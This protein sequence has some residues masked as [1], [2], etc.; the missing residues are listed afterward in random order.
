MFFFVR[1]F[2]QA[3]KFCPVAMYEYTL[4]KAVTENSKKRLQFSEKINIESQRSHDVSS[5]S[6]VHSPLQTPRVKPVFKSSDSRQC[7]RFKT[8]TSLSYSCKISFQLD[9]CFNLEIVQPW[10]S[11]EKKYLRIRRLDH[12][13]IHWKISIFFYFR[14]ESETQP[15]KMLE[16][17]L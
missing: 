9:W 17:V 12:V 6:H 10:Y 8:L 16:S 1:N 4:S 2:W 13:Q 3:R 7:L 5:Q 11:L 15:F 14:K